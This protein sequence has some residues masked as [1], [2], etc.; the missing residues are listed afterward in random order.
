MATKLKVAKRVLPSGHIVHI[1]P[2]EKITSLHNVFSAPDIGTWFYSPDSSPLPSKKRWIFYY[3]FSQ[4]KIYVDE[5]AKRA[6]L[7]GS[8]LLLPGIHKLEGSFQKKDIVEISTLEGEVFAK[9]EINYSRKE[10]E[11]A[12][13]ERRKLPKEVI[14]RDQMVLFPKK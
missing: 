12:L 14:H 6:L 5:G 9:G 1:F 10:I 2:G 8:S 11:K 7:R 4:G 13:Q 3:P